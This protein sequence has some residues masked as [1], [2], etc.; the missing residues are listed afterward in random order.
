MKRSTP[1]GAL[2]LAPLLLARGAEG[3]LV[4]RENLRPGTPDFVVVRDGTAAAAGVTDVYP[5]AWSIARG[6]PVRLKIRAAD[7]FQVSLFRLGWYGGDGAR[8]VTTVGPHPAVVQPYPRAEPT[9]GL[10]EAGWSDA[11]TIATDGSWAPGVYLAR[12]DLAGGPQA[13]TFFVIR[14]DGLVPRS[15]L[16]VVVPLATHAAYDAWPGPALGGKSLYAFN[17]S[18]DVPSDSDSNQAVKVSLDRPFYVMGGIADLTHDQYPFV[19]WVERE[20]FDV[21]YATDE[22]VH[23]RADVTQGRGAIAFVGHSEYWSRAMREAVK[24]ARDAGT[25]LLFATGDTIAYQ[26]RFEPGA[27][28]ATSTIVGYKESREKDP[29]Q[30]AGLDAYY[31]AD[32]GGAKAHLRMVTRGWRDVMY[33]PSLHLDE[34][35]PGMTLTGVHTSHMIHHAYPWADLIIDDASLWFFAGTTLGRGSVIAGIM[36]YAVDTTEP[37]D[38]AWD[39]FRP[40]GQRAFASIVDRGTRLGGSSYYRAASGAEIVALGGIAFDAAL[41]D[42]NAP[43]A[44]VSPGA[45]QLVRNLLGRWAPRLPDLPDPAADAG[46]SDTQAPAPAADA[47]VAASSDAQASTPPATSDVTLDAADAAEAD[48]E[49]TPP[50]ETS[51][52]PA[53]D[54]EIDAAIDAAI[55]PPRAGCEGGGCATAGRSG[56]RTLAGCGFASAIAFAARR[57]RRGPAARGD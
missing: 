44:T 18:P 41:D 6:E 23:A 31:A 32:L 54:A 57:R 15:P 24:G 49:E 21:A 8:L 14:D 12:V 37:G 19:R 39:P 36:G 26:I 4:A 33:E 7:A 29:E 11:V 25:N 3:G 55:E 52:A 50:F 2:A 35:D 20:G 28:G 42:Y 10:V 53:I 30:I 48:S 51:T 27:G 5:A 13:E 1:L 17:C 22:D 43:F 46:A 40:A 16:L 47:T 34:R 38:P 9:F 45:Q 56:A